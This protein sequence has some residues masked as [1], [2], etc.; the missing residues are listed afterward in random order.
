[1]S[2][3]RHIRQASRLAL[4]EGV[5]GFRLLVTRGRGDTFGVTLEETYGENGGTI[6]TTVSTATP[7]QT[8]RVVD[9]LFVAVRKAG[10]QTSALAFKRKAPILLSE[11]EGVRLALVLLATQPIAKHERVRALVTGI[12]AMSVEETYYWYAK[13]MGIDGNRARK[14]LRTLLAN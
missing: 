8:G 12:N 4:V 10:Y 14:A 2:T 9:A 1:M 3:V 6:S 5:R 7:A 11:A 13:C